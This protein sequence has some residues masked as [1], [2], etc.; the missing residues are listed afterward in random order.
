MNLDHTFKTT[1][2]GLLSYLSARV[3]CEVAGTYWIKRPDEKSADNRVTITAVDNLL[4]RTWCGRKW[5]K[6]DLT[7]Y[8]AAGGNGDVH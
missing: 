3:T 8:D 1:S 4:E 7:R 2:S 6:R 5:Q